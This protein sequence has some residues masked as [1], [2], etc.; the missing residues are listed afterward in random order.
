M[1]TF[2]IKD[3]HAG[4]RIDATLALLFPDYS[5]S[6]LARMI[7]FGDVKV[8]ET[9][10]PLKYKLKSEDVV[11]I[12]LY[13]LEQPKVS[14]I[15][16]Q[17]IYED[18]DV[19]VINKPTGLLAHSKGEY[20]PEPSVA[21][22]LKSHYSSEATAE[23]QAFWRSNRAGIVH[24]LDRATS[25]VMICAKNQD[26]L[27]HL[28]KQFATRK[29]K[30]SYYAIISLGLAPPKALVD[31]PIE[32]NPKQPNKFRVSVAGKAAQTEYQIT[33]SSAS[34]SKVLLKP[35]TGRTHQLRV[36]LKQLGHPILG[37]TL[38]DGT[39]FERLMLHAYSLEITLPDKT[40]QTFVSPLP[41]AFNE[42]L[43]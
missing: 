39:P 16:I 6:S 31:M 11:A 30:K 33:E 24:R 27:S 35:I 12:K 26:S 20:N 3:S 25:G 34:L 38:Y 22:W 18:K 19:V 13:S 41:R 43:N 37:D 32:R 40:R 28:Q 9:I 5:R 1:Q 36:H 42:N 4:K 21:S 17:V 2:K 8:N 10:V 15:E 7:K 29:V 14:D 23:E